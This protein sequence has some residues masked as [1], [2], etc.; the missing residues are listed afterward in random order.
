MVHGQTARGQI[1]NGN[2][3][4]AEQFIHFLSISIVQNNKRLGLSR[5]DGRLH[6]T[7]DEISVQT[8]LSLFWVLALQFQRAH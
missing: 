5:C 8:K 4:L 7:L 3:R 6:A 1:P 2:L